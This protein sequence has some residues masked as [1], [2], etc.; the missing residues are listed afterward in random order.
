METEWR[1]ILEWWEFLKAQGI[2]IYTA[3]W[4]GN[5]EIGRLVYYEVH[6]FSDFYSRVFLSCEM[7]VS[8][9]ASQT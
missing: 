3:T 4:F 2:S 5:Q 8:A 9:T 1:E 7:I 6:F